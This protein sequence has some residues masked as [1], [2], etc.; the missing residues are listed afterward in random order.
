MSLGK[1][2]F[3]PRKVLVI[4]K[5]RWLR[6]DMT[7]KLLTGTLNHKTN[8]SL[9]TVTVEKSQFWNYHSEINKIVRCSCSYIL[10]FKNMLSEDLQSLGN[11]ILNPSFDGLSRQPN[12]NELLEMNLIFQS[13][14]LL[15]FTLSF[16][17]SHRSLHCAIFTIQNTLIIFINIH[18]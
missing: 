5:K 16:L 11:N 8:E 12:Q 4:P 15:I 14:V 18:F 10:L 6:P 2:T 13:L 9:H 7:E 3:A 17:I 1:N